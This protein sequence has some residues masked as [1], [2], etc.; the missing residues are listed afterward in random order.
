MRGVLLRSVTSVS[1]QGKQAQDIVI[2]P[3]RRG[4]FPWTGSDQIKHHL[5]WVPR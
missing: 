3:R 5:S 4:R 2:Q 1:L